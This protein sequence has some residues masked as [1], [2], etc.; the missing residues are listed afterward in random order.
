MQM[1]GKI[2]RGVV[3]DWVEGGIKVRLKGYKIL[4]FIRQVGEVT[5][6]NERYRP[7]V[8]MR[9]TGRACYFDATPRVAG[10]L[11]IRALRGVG[12]DGNIGGVEGHFRSRWTT[13][14][15]LSGS[16]L[17]LACGPADFPPLPIVFAFSTP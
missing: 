1:G 5:P 6:T 12:R 3:G 4:S 17:D 9:V 15:T 14:L 7:G 8:W 2:L 16:S 10:L 13:W 11:A